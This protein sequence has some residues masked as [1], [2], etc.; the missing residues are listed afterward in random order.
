MGALWQMSV[1]NA[2]RW[3]RWKFR[4]LHATGRIDA[5][6][7][8]E[9][10][11]Q[12]LPLRPA[13]HPRPRADQVRRREANERLG[14]LDPHRARVDQQAAREVIDGKLD[15]HFVLDI[16]QTGSGTSTNMNANEVIANRATQLLAR[17]RGPRPPKT[18]HPASI[19]TTT[20][21]WASRPTT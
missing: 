1:S 16:F 21:T 2:I 3:A 20:S 19:P 13:V 15:D 5:A 18:M 12:R 7:G 4:L 17:L 11:D 8:A 6:G 10:P 14:R 9:L